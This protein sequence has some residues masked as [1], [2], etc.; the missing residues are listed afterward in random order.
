MMAVLELCFGVV[1]VM[2][3]VLVSCSIG[4]ATMAWLVAVQD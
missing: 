3:G 4:M 2:M 1:V